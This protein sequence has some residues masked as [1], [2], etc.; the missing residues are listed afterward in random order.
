[1]ASFE[2]KILLSMA[3]SVPPPS[4]PGQNPTRRELR[5]VLHPLSRLSNRDQKDK[6]SRHPPRRRRSKAA[7][8]CLQSREYTFTETIPRQ[9]SI[10]LVEVETSIQMMIAGKI[11]KLGHFVVP[12]SGNIADALKL[13]QTADFE[14][15]VLDINVCGDRIGPVAEMINGGHLPFVF[16]SG[17]GGR[18]PRTI[19]RS[20]SV[21]KTISDGAVGRGDR[22]SARRERF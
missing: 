11:E 22:S 4:D 20:T 6:I 16:A 17:F 12:E 8:Y 13:A 9:V 18:R 14:I 5:V 10:L 3:A 21:A 15:A 7:T 1:V 19:T 2:T